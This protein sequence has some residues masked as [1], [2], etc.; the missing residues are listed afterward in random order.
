MNDNVQID[1][2]FDMLE[3]RQER[4]RKSTIGEWWRQAGSCYYG[5]N[6][7]EGITRVTI[8]DSISTM[9]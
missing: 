4:I 5:K 7:S 6:V 1:E 9:N 8:P 2:L 3:M